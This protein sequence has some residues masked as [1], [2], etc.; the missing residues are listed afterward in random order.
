MTVSQA[1]WRCADRGTRAFGATKVPQTS[2]ASSACP[3][4]QEDIREPFPADLEAP[5]AQCDQE[6]NLQDEADPQI[7]DFEHCLA[8]FFTPV[9]A[10]VARRVPS[11]D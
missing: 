3:D 9:A 5:I 2:A 11:P 8:Q 6:A 1:S 4:A 10:T 7:S